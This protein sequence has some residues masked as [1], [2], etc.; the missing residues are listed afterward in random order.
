MKLQTKT[1]LPHPGFTLVEMLLVVTIIGIL[2]ALVIPRI[3]STGG[4]ARDAAVKADLNGGIKSALG[5]Y[6]I[7][8]GQYP[9]NLQDLLVQPANAQHWHGPYLEKM[10]VDPW[11]NVYVYHMPG[12]HNPDYDLLSVGPD[13]K[14]GTADDIGNWQ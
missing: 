7:D 3:T 8:V 13:A 2:A 5:H 14:E 1:P 10:P 9:K 12:R 4:R 11:G 6:E